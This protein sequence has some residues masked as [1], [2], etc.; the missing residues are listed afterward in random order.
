[1]HKWTAVFWV[2]GLGALLLSAF[3]YV[4]ILHLVAGAEHARGT[5]TGFSRSGSAFFPVIAFKTSEGTQTE[6][7]GQSGSSSPTLVRGQ[8]VDVI[9]R[10]ENPTNARINTFADIWGPTLFL[11]I[12]G[13]I[14]S[15]IGLVPI[16]IRWNRGHTAADVRLHGTAVLAE[17]DHVA[18]NSSVSVRGTKPYRIFVQWQDPATSQVHVFHSD[19]IWYDPEKFIDRKQL[20]VYVDPGN[21]KRYSVD[22]S[23]LPPAAT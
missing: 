7:F 10:P 8:Q 12:F 14:F 1:M 21:L 2:I 17:Y 6:F 22:I 20:T 13:V 15:T 5:V 9:Y 11:S 16:F 3:S 18:V 4:N 19:D 23:F